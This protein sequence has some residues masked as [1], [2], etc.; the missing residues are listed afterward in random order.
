MLPKYLC[1]ALSWH[2]HKCAFKRI[3]LDY[4]QSER[5]KPDNHVVILDSHKSWC[6]RTFQKENTTFAGLQFF[7]HILFTSCFVIGPSVHTVLVRVLRTAFT[8][9]VQRQVWMETCLCSLIKTILL[10]I[11]SAAVFRPNSIVRKDTVCQVRTTNT[12]I[13][14]RSYSFTCVYV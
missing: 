10:E 13:R 12:K 8:R 2:A 7:K 9:I 6:Q 5:G 3:P 1:A 14:L 11:V 4:A